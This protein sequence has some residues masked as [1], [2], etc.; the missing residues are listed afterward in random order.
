MQASV[1]ATGMKA[2][3]RVYLAP[4]RDGDALLVVY[5]SCKEQAQL[6]AKISQ[7]FARSQRYHSSMAIGCSPFSILLTWGKPR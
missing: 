1:Q 3:S 4:C 7:S 6:G 5:L 2:G